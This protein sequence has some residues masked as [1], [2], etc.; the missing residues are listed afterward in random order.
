MQTG[1]VK[2]RLE[3]RG[4]FQLCPT[5]KNKLSKNFPGSCKT[6]KRPVQ[7]NICGLKFE[8][9]KS[10]TQTRRTEYKIIRKEAIKLV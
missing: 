5:L 6:T 7:T 9:D 3:S 4:K 2:D 1:T 8:P 10:E